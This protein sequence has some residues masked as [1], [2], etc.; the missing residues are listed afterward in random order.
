MPT[1]WRSI[2][3]D[4][5]LQLLMAACSKSNAPNPADFA[6]VQQQAERTAPLSTEILEQKLGSEFTKGHEALR[7][8]G[9]QLTEQSRQLTEQGQ[10]AETSK[11]LN[12]VPQR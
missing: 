9:R 5:P 12:S 6:P 10:L 11:N 2:H 7:E 8:Q 3:C 4:Q 1:M